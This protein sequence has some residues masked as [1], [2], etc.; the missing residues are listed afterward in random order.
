M[1]VEDHAKYFSEIRSLAK[2]YEGKIKI[3]AGLEA[4]Y[5]PEFACD[6]D[7]AYKEFSPDVVSPSENGRSFSFEGNQKEKTKD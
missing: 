2:E 6:F 4:D 3:Y 1:D 7:W 5:I